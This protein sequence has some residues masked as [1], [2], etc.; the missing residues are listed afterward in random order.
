MMMRQTVNLYFFVRFRKK[1][2]DEKEH[3]YTNVTYSNNAPSQYTNNGFM[4]DSVMWS[5]YSLTFCW[6]RGQSCQSSVPCNRS[7]CF[8]VIISYVRAPYFLFTY[9]MYIVSPDD[10]DRSDIS[11]SNFDGQTVVCWCANI[12]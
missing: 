6:L 2:L 4:L 8:Y 12:I 5:S 10:I 9:N 11:A 1:R 7:P 3:A